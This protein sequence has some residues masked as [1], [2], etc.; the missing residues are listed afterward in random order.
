M[1]NFKVPN[2]KDSTKK[3][4]VSDLQKS[5]NKNKKQKRKK[6]HNEKRFIDDVK[7]LQDDGYD[8]DYLDNFEKW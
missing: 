8:V 3:E 2:K 5:V 7:S 6:R 1:E 4:D